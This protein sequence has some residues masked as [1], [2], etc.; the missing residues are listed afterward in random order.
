MEKII[1]ID[2]MR[3][4][5][6][7]ARVEKALSQ[8]GQVKVDLSAKSACVL[9][10]TDDAILKDEVESLGFDVISIVTK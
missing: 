2:G 5:K 1:Q 4:E 7:Q 6:C 8:F 9:C 10:D 3:C